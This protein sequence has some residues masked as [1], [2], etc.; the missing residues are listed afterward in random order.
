M[1]QTHNI[2]R[3]IN[4][5]CVGLELELSDRYVKTW[6]NETTKTSLAGNQRECL[7]FLYLGE[8]DP[9]IRGTSSYQF[10]ASASDP[11]WQL[12][13]TVTQ[14]AEHML[15]SWKRYCMTPSDGIADHTLI[16]MMSHHNVVRT[17]DHFHLLRAEFMQMFNIYLHDFTNWIHVA[18]WLVYSLPADCLMAFTE[19]QIMTW[20]DEAL[21]CYT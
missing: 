4:L 21:N 2:F 18:G 7:W 11:T 17:L 16:H 14:T 3:S 8:S 20:L 13:S 1:K 19:T 12:L 15:Q 5:W 10:D 9:S 6:R